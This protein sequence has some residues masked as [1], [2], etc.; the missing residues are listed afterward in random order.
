MPAPR[1]ATVAPAVLHALGQ[2]LARAYWYKD[3]LRR[4]LTHC[5]GN[6]ALVG[7]LNW[8]ARKWEIAGELV[9]R[10]KAR[11][12]LYQEDLIRLVDETCRMNDFSHLRRLEDGREKAEA[13][14][15]AVDALRRVAAEGLELREEL[16][17]AQRLRREKADRRE[18]AMSLQGRI[19]ELR[20][21]YL[22][23]FAMPPQARGFELEDLLSEL[24]DIFDLDP[25]RS[26]RLTGEQV[27]GA[28]AFQGID[29]LLECKWHDSLIGPSHLRDFAGKVRGKLE[30]TLGLFLSVS[31][32]TADA[33]GAIA[34][35]GS[36][37]ILM[38]GEDLMAV[39]DARVGL[40]QFL[41]RKRRHAAQTGNVYLRARD[42]F[43]RG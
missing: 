33:P 15:E 19:E 26:F 38:D 34:G 29:Y 22:Q 7:S 12:D 25:K 37:V 28:F 17:R 23:L 6:P 39:L 43:S 16:E 30:N 11:E 21:R 36:V 31:G 18:A 9:D 5:L 1:R 3:D 32:F 24:F 14:A 8:S 13:A 40:D 2:A 4:Y 35:P 42:I 20:G 27:D 41:L 10:L